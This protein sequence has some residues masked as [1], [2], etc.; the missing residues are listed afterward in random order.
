MSTLIGWLFG[1]GAR[2]RRD[3]IGA[4]TRARGGGKRAVGRTSTSGECETEIRVSA[5]VSLALR[6]VLP[7]PPP[8]TPDRARAA[9]GRGACLMYLTADDDGARVEVQWHQELVAHI[10]THRHRNPW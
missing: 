3:H 4:S 1:T 10:S 2:V 8:H 6:V 7:V 9:G 5:E